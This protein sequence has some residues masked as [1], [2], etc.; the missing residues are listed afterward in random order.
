MKKLLGKLNNFHPSAKFTCE[1][2]CEK[3]NYLDVQVIV[4]EGKLITVLYVKR[5]DSHQYLD[6]LLCHPYHHTKSIPYSRALRINLICS[7]NVSFDLRRSELEDCLIKR[8]YNP[9]VVRKQILKTRAFSGDT[10][11]HRVKEN[12]NSYRLVLTLTY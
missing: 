1:Y 10:L 5:T 11:L 2:S 12:K 3:V 9:T 7:E 6:S 4:G 8:N